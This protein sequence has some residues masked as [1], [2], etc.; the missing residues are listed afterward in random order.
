MGKAPTIRDNRAMPDPRSSVSAIAAALGPLVARFDVD[1]IAEC[2]ST[3]TQLLVRAD[4]APSGT[5]LVAERQTAGRGR[6]G[7]NWCAEP[8]VSL[9]FSLLWRLPRGAVASGLSLAA[10]IAVAEALQSLCVDGVGLK[11]PNDI[12]RDGRKLGGILVE[13]A[14]SVAVIGIGLNLRLPVG[15]PPD[16]RANAAA[17]EIDVDRNELVAR[18]LMSL[19]GVLDI[20]GSGGFA[21]LRD[22]WSALDTYAGAPVRIVSGDAAPL[23][24]RSTGVDIDGALLLDNGAGVQRVISGDVSLRAG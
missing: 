4:G 15:L 3:N 8:D 12:L 24:G 5:V 6:M 17:L 2:D 20:F 22:R 10:G 23:E 18:L 9:T 21:P 7:R 11:W 16:V 14:S 1:V 19:Q 13:L